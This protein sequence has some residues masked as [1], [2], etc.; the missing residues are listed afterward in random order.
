MGSRSNNSLEILGSKQQIREVLTF[1]KGKPDQNGDVMVFDF[2]RVIPVPEEFIN[3]NPGSVRDYLFNPEESTEDLSPK[4]REFLNSLIIKGNIESLNGNLIPLQIS[5][6][7]HNYITRS[8]SSNDFTDYTDWCLT[9]WDSR[10][11]ALDQQMVGENMIS[12]TTINGTAKVVI[13]KLSEMFPKLVLIYENIRESP[14]DDI[15]I[16]EDGKLVRHYWIDY[17]GENAA[18]NEEILGSFS[19]LGSGLLSRYIR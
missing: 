8:L 17:S 11:N 10:F 4:T 13:H 2:S 1:I 5:E 15:R 12:F 6:K 3:Q 9:K 18:N 19:K 14:D 7:Y 16:F